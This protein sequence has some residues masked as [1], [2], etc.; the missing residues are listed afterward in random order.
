MSYLRT[1]RPKQV[2]PTTTRFVRPR[3]SICV[4][5]INISLGGD[6][7]SPTEWTSWVV[8]PF[9]SCCEEQSLARGE[10]GVPGAAVW[11][12][13]GTY[14]NGCER[15]SRAWREE[16]RGCPVPRC[17]MW[18][19]HTTTAVSGG[20]ELAER[21]AGGARCRGVGCG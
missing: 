6:A 13:D 4:S 10:R 1:I 18:M 20:A 7:S 2:S 3:V 12:V 9:L 16:S 8:V 15:R 19:E 11:D 17:G 14:N 21:R 5:R